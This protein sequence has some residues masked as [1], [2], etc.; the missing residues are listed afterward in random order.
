M[1]APRAQQAIAALP[2]RWSQFDHKTCLMTDPDKLASAILR[3]VCAHDG[4]DLEAVVHALGG[5]DQQIHD[6]IDGLLRDGYL[7]ADKVL[8]GDDGVM[9]ARG[10]RCTHKGSQAIAGGAIPSARTMPATVNEAWQNL[11][12]A[13]E[14]FSGAE[15]E[16]KLAQ[17]ALMERGAY[18]SGQSIAEAMRVAH[19]AGLRWDSRRRRFQK[20]LLERLRNKLIVLAGT[21]A[22]F[23]PL[24]FRSEETSLSEAISSAAT[25]AAVFVALYSV[26]RDRLD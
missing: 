6:R 12:D 18:N 14:P 3:E 17:A 4:V 24:V 9:S 5:Y 26:V 21:L 13:V 11:F 23:L 19:A 10:L 2:A 1:A 15:R 8:A 25:V 7:S 22:T 16:A 20:P